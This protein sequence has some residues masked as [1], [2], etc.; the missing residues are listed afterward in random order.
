MSGNRHSNVRCCSPIIASTKLINCIAQIRCACSLI[1]PL[2]SGGVSLNMCYI[3]ANRANMVRNACRLTPRKNIGLVC[4]P[5]RRR[6]RRNS[7]LIASN[8]SNALPGKLIINLTNRVA[9]TSGKLSTRSI[10]DLAI[11]IPRLGAICIV[12]SFSKGNSTC[13]R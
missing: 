5:L 13:R 12:A 3:H 1:A 8:C 10:M 11:S 6:V 9:P 7:V 4:V 2:L